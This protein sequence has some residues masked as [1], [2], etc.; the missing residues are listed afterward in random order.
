MQKYVIVYFIDRKSVP[1]NFLA[2]EW[3]LHITLLANFTI[4]NP[5]ES[6]IAKL[7]DLS[8]QIEPIATNV[9]GEDMF[10]LNKD[11]A[12][13]L[14]KQNK[15]LIKLH[16]NLITITESLGAEYDEPKFLGEG[17]RP[18]A[19]IQIKSRL[20]K[21]QAVNINSFTLIDMFPDNDKTRRRIIKDF[22]LYST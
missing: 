3:P 19:T 2:S 18:H 16:G 22:V 17:F 6:L 9:L 14:I 21:G 20:H 10:G 8:K 5:I 15:E 4:A 7:H 1:D 11:V 12:V 13:S